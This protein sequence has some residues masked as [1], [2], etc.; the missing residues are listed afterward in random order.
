MFLNRV[1]VFVL[2]CAAIVLAPGYLFW[3]FSMGGLSPV[4]MHGQPGSEVLGFI[5]QSSVASLFCSNSYAIVFSTLLVWQQCK[6]K[7]K[8]CIMFGLYGVA[9]RV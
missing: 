4:D 3:A 9:A 8:F 1:P 2:G 7:V 6:N 5:F